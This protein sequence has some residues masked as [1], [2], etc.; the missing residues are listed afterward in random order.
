MR[1]F[2]EVLSQHFTV[3]CVLFLCAHCS[4]GGGGGEHEGEGSPRQPA[5]AHG[6]RVLPLLSSCS[7]LKKAHFLGLHTDSHLHH[8]S[9]SFPRSC[10]AGGTP[11]H[12][13]GGT[14]GHSPGGTTARGE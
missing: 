12:S 14:S 7:T 13:P 4:T 6:G 2:A 11:G 9:P 1:R 10:S 8:L 5:P 3:Y